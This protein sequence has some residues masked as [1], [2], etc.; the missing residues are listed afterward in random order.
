VRVPNASN[1]VTPRYKQLIDQAVN[2]ADEQALKATVHEVTQI[3]LDEA[4]ILPF[5]EGAGQL[6]GPEAVHTWVNDTRWDGVGWFGYQDVWL[7]Q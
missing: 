1:F 5:A 7:S 2:L 4:F 3:M 6:A